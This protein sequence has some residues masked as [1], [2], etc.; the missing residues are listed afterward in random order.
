MP[1]LLVRP[2]LL[3]R[4][5]PAVREQP[6]LRVARVLFYQDELPRD[7]VEVRVFV[8]RRG[9]L[10]VE[11]LGHVEAV[12]PHLRWINLLVPEASLVRARLRPQLFAQKRGGT[13]VLLLTRDVVESEQKSARHDVVEAVV[14]RFVSSD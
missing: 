12:E 9:V 8:E 14:F 11:R 1:R 7:V 5:V 6:R 2:A 3:P 13:P 4:L 10:R